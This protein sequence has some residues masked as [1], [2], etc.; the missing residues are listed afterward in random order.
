MKNRTFILAIVALIVVALYIYK[1]TNEN[2]RLREAIPYLLIGEIIDYFDL[3]RADGV[4]VDSTYLNTTDDR[5]KVIF[6]FESPCSA[7]NKNL[8]FWKRMVSQGKRE[9][10]IDVFGIIMGSSEELMNAANLNFANF[11]LYCPIDIEQFKKSLHLKINLPQTILYKNKQVI[12]IKLGMLLLSDF[13]E[14]KAKFKG[15]IR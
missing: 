1:I 8:T 6:I 15:D 9:K 5:L 11:D 7:C 2:I 14:I 10:D 4:N 13:H 12:Y 3:K